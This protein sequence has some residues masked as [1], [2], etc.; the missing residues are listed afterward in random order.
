MFRFTIRD[1]LWLTVVVALD[2]SSLADD[3]AFDHRS[4]IKATTTTLEKE[5]YS[6]RKLDDKLS[7][8][9]LAAFVAELDPRRM[10]FLQSDIA[11][12]Q[13]FE[14]LLDDHAKTG[15]FQFP[16]LVRTRYRERVAT[17]AA[18]AIK[19]INAK[20][21]FTI[22]ESIPVRFEGYSKT[23]DE[24]QER[25][26]LTIKSELLVEKAHGRPLDEVQSQLRG[27][28]ERI[29]KQA[30]ELTDAQLCEIYLVSLVQ[31]YDPHSAYL[32][33]Y[34]YENGPH[35]LLGMS[36]RYE[37]GRYLIEGI[38]PSLRTDDS[39][40]L[41]GWDLMAVRRTDGEL[42]D[43]VERQPRYKLFEIIASPIGP[44]ESDDRITLELRHPVMLARR[45]I[46]WPRFRR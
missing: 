17:A 35:Y 41:L 42:I 18:D 33:E 12:F 29:A 5:H 39:F 10:Y 22:D 14:Q 2:L 11:D 31:L 20:H 19:W 13:P 24:R 7:A 15:D 37:R 38:H 3:S 32:G 45:S 40:S 28:Y 8:E 36:L 46:E 16:E 23:A 9:W 34:T 27:R 25:W 6:H 30:R 26:R 44:L 4:A 43:L 21:D 1:V